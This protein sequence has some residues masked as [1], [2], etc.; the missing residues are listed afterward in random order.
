MFLND[1]VYTSLPQRPRP[2]ER[3]AWTTNWFA[4]ES[5]DIT[6]QPLSV[7]VNPLIFLAFY[8]EDAYAETLWNQVANRPDNDLLEAADQ[9]WRDQVGWWDHWKDCLTANI[10]PQRLGDL[11]QYDRT[12]RAPGGGTYLIPIDRDSGEVPHVVGS[13]QEQILREA[14]IK[15]QVEV[16]LPLATRR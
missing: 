12:G 16:I 13:V 11:L 2:D 1:D 6:Q 4:S 10:E 9:W 7:L 15:E 5:T 3:R 8:N 14:H